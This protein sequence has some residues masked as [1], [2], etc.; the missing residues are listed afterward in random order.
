MVCSFFSLSKLISTCCP[1]EHLRASVNSSTDEMFFLSRDFIIS[2][3]FNPESRA[4]ALTF[5]SQ[6]RTSPIAETK[7]PS[8]SKVTPIACPPGIKHLVLLSETFLALVTKNVPRLP[9]E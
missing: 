6:V 8:V 1:P 7:T 2:P 3:P 5:P 4:G 9:V